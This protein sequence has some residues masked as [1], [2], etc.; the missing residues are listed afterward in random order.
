M[1]IKVDADKSTTF[2]IKLHIA[3]TARNANLSGS[4]NWILTKQAPVILENYISLNVVNNTGCNAIKDASSFKLVK[5]TGDKQN[6]FKIVGAVPTIQDYTATNVSELTNANNAEFYYFC[7]NT[8]VVGSTG[9]NDPG[10]IYYTSTEDNT[11]ENWYNVPNSPL[12]LYSCFMKPNCT[13]SET[14]SGTDTQVIISNDKTII[15]SNE[16][17]NNSTMVNIVIPQSVQTIGRYQDNYAP[18]SNCSK[19]EKIIIPNSV[20]AI[21]GG[22]FSYCTKLTSISIGSKALVY[23]SAFMYCKNLTSI[24]VSEDNE[25]CYSYENCLLQKQGDFKLLRGCKNSILPAGLQ[26]IGSYAFSGC[27]GLT[28]ISLPNSIK[29]IGSNAFA[30]CA[31]LSSIAIPSGITVIDYNVFNLCT[32]LTSV[33]IP[34]G[35]T[36]ISGGAFYGCSKLAEITIPSSVTK[37][38]INA[39]GGCTGLASATFEESGASWTVVKSGST[40]KTTIGVPDPAQNATY[41]KSTYSSY[42]W[43][44]N[45]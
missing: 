21:F 16:I 45:S 2:S 27:S 28:T 25:D 23:E 11:L 33:V 9:Y 15:D 31:D 35:V 17:C 32:S 37:I 3:N 5:G 38:G 41:L 12:N 26:Y 30:E 19:L 36:T 22:V 10:E 42:T 44:K 13:A 6:K 40:K 24:T 4:L 1:P 20:G 8:A 34:S 7:T 43:T 39:F 29:S 14:Y 18:F